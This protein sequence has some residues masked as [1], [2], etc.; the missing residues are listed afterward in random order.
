[1]P[2]LLSGLLVLA[3]I[4]ATSGCSDDSPGTNN[5]NA[6]VCGNGTSVTS[7]AQ[8]RLPTSVQVRSLYYTDVHKTWVKPVAVAFTR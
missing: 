3:L 4:A 7:P 8:S 2:K 1:M 5:N 6:S